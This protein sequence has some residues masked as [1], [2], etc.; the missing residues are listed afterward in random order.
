MGRNAKLRKAKQQTYIG[1]DWDIYQ[2]P[3]TGKS[4]L[5]TIYALTA[6][7]KRVV[8]HQYNPPQELGGNSFG[9]AMNI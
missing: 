2:D 7:G 4:Y 5:K 6:T 8:K 3:K 1:L 9:P